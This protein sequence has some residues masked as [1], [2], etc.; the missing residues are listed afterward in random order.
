MGCVVSHRVEG[1]L[2]L[3]RQSDERITCPWIG[4]TAARRARRVARRGVMG[5]VYFIIKLNPFH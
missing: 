1:A 4:A 2:Q 3:V 5:G